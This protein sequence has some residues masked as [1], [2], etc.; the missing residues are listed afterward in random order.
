MDQD[1]NIAI[2]NDLSVKPMRTSKAAVTSLI[3]GIL[4]FLIPV[5]I[6]V[7]GLIFG[8]IGLR[9]IRKSNGLLKG[10]GLAVAGTTVSSVSLV[11]W[12][13]PVVA[14]LVWM[15]YARMNIPEFERT[16]GYSLVCE[17][18]SGDKLDHSTM[19]EICRKL[20][21]RVDPHGWNGVM[22]RPEEGASLI[23]I[24]V[25]VRESWQTS[26]NDPK[27]LLRLLKGAGV[28]EFRILPTEEDDREKLS[29]YRQALLT[30]GSTKTSDNQYVW[31][32]IEDPDQWP[33]G[34]GI[35]ANSDETNYVLCSNQQSQI[36]L[37][38]DKDE[39]GIKKAYDSPDSR[40]YPA[41]GFVFDD[42]AADR[43][44]RLTSENLGKPLAILMD[45]EVISAP[46]INSAIRSAG[47]IT[48][49]A[50][51]F[52]QTEVSDMINILNAGSLPVPVRAM[53]ETLKWTHPAD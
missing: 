9:N 35:L 18:G 42:V 7:V 41:I 4:G 16:G 12:L 30:D 52:T 13:V 20:K 5:I 24:C 19:D 47:L 8:I 45:N 22:I 43:F 32:A 53:P 26:I 11:L 3:L 44:F 27:D 36:M 37:M 14:L 6:A 29:V 49:G 17:V 38:G 2:H 10:Q 1:S 50:A 21:E 25:P 51:G 46:R 48:G 34:L 33:D 31:C 39:G 23:E 15:L 40:G 28:L